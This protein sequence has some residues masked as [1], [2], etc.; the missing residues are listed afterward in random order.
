MKD[1][2]TILKMFTARMD[3]LEDEDTEVNMWTFVA[4]RNNHYNE[5]TII[6]KN[7]LAIEDFH[8][9]EIRCFELYKIVELARKAI[10]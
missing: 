3:I 2:L 6:G 9:G 10:L 1:T 7:Y 4:D 8:D 5:S